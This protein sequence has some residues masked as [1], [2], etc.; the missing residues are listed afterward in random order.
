MIQIS[1]GYKIV[2]KKINLLQNSLEK[3]IKNLEADVSSLDSIHVAEN[4]KYHTEMQKIQSHDKALKDVVDAYTKQLVD[5]LDHR[6]NTD[7]TC[8]LATLLTEK[9]A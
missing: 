4:S 5:D 1:E 8:N 9:T 2:S 6:W 7:W 3:E